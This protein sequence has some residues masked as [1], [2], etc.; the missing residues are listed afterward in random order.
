MI[1]NGAFGLIAVLALAA[2]NEASTEGSVVEDSEGLDAASAPSTEDTAE[3]A[4]NE[5]DYATAED[6]VAEPEINWAQNEISGDGEIS[7]SRKVQYLIGKA[8]G[9]SRPIS[10]EEKNEA[11]RNNF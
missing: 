9:G 1:M 10:A 2:C 5:A 8:A 3:V 11:I 4:S 7:D 6:V